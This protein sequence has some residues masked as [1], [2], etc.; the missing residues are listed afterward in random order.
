MRGKHS[1]SILVGL[2]ALLTVMAAC[3]DSTEEEP[4]A[5]DVDEQTD[6]NTSEGN[7][8]E[9]D[10]SVVIT[11]TQLSFPSQVSVPAGKTVTWVNDSS[12]PHEVQMDTL[13]GNP[14]DMEALRV[15]VDEQGDMSLEEGTWA[16]FCAIHPSMTGTLVVGG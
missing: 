15:G 7:V 2:I 16:Y 4:S 5:T 6:T 12:A 11:I 10:T 13:D 14:V 8:S 9:T 1:R 3:S